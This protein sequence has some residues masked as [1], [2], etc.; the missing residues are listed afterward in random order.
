MTNN[1]KKV[2]IKDLLNYE[3][4][5]KYIVEND[6][7]TDNGIAVLTA[8]KSFILGYTNETTG[9]Y[10]NIP[11]IIF[12][13]FTTDI[14][15]VDFP[16]KVKSS[17]IK[18]LKEKNSHVDLLFVYE[19]MSSRTFPNGAHKRYYISQYQNMEVLV[20]P[21]E[22]QHKIASILFSVTEAI[23]KTDEIIQKTELLK[24]G[25]M[26]ELLTKGIGHKKF[27]KTKLG[28]IPEEWDI[29]DL[30]QITLNITDGKHGDCKNEA[31]SGYYFISVKDIRDGKINYQD[32]RQITK[33][34]F[35]ETHK[36]TKLEVGDLLLTNSGTIGRMAVVQD[37]DKV[38][39]TTFQKSVA[40]IKPDK[41]KIN[42]Y[43]L[44]HSITLAIEKLTIQSSGSAQ[45]NLLLKDLRS[46]S[47]PL[48]KIQEQDQISDI[49]QGL[50]LKIS[51][52]R[53]KKTQL[54][55]LK[56][57]LMQDIFNQKVQIN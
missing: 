10:K 57:G 42:V 19:L 3:R 17:A 11:V 56:T 37:N 34:D 6:R 28:E 16:F 4:P 35:D 24:Q 26:K 39:R 15:Y 51:R 55:L 5:D 33:N 45:V 23:R 7:Y 40:V 50:D 1:W 53:L 18:I 54:L 13:D 29:K 47:I 44:M 25:L 22:M 41:S 32:A 9:I 49:L 43:Y 36:R 52:E 38:A 31:N 8:N 21:V 27:K 20:P 48:P 2:K 12:D 14:K 30:N 46:F